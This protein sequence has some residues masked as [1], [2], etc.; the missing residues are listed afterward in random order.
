MEHEDC[1]SEHWLLGEKFED[2]GRTYLVR[3]VGH[4]DVEEGQ[5]CCQSISRNQ[6]E[7]V[8]ILRIF[9]PFGKLGHHARVNLYGDNLLG[10]LQEKLGEI[11]CPWPNLQDDIS[12]SNGRFGDHLVQDV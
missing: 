1:T 3:N 12:G 8:S 10:P 7:L 6:D 2:Q 9:E 4:T 11:T 5:L